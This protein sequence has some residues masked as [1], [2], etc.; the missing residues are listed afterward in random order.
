MKHFPPSLLPSPLPPSL[1]KDV[2]EEGKSRRATNKCEQSSS[3]HENV[4]LLM[5]ACPLA[6]GVLRRLRPWL[7]PI[8]GGRVPVRYEVVHTYQRSRTWG[9]AITKR[10]RGYRRIKID[11]GVGE[12]GLL[13]VL[14]A[15]AITKPAAHLML[16][17]VS[18]KQAKTTPTWWQDH[19]DGRE[20][21]LLFR[22]TI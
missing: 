7:R 19:L 1:V 4:F 21:A 9:E 14:H 11:S 20:G 10:S 18:Q 12:G 5:I 16:S 6:Q 8:P 3:L 2:H 17:T 15:L 22:Q 13:R